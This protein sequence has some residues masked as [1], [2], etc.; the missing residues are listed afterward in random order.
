MAVERKK[1]VTAN[2]DACNEGDRGSRQSWKELR[3]YFIS[4]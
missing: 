3:E 2:C 4:V 1:I